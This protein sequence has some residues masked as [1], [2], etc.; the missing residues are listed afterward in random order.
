MCIN[1]GIDQESLMRFGHERFSSQAEGKRKS[2]FTKIYLE[3]RG[4]QVHV[5]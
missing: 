2:I 3:R 4:I 1:F 5:V